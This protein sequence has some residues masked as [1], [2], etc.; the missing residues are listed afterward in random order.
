M[1]GKAAAKVSGARDTC[2]CGWEAVVEAFAACAGGSLDVSACGPAPASAP[3][4]TWDMLVDAGC[5]FED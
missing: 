1:F 5:L 2:C 3:A 4:C